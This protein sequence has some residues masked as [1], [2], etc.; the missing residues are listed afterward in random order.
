MTSLTCDVPA[1]LFR[2][3]TSRAETTGSNMS[4]LVS[5]LLTGSLD[6]TFHT[7]FQ[8][9]TSS[10]LIQGVYAQAVTCQKILEHGDFGLG[11]FTGLDGEMVVL[12]SVVYRVQGDGTVSKAEPNAGAPFAVV[13]SF[14]PSSDDTVGPFSSFQELKSVCD[15]HRRSDNLF[16]AIR[17]DGSF[18]HVRTR[19]VSPPPAGGRLVDAAKSQKEFNYSDVGGTLVGIYS[20]TFS[21]AFSV[22]GYHFH[23]LSDDRL[24]G[25]HVLDVSADSLRLRVEELSAFHLAL[26]ETEPFLQADLSHASAA[27]LKKSES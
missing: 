18:S 20:P 14:S 17:V 24:D 19:A 21:G 7:L 25:G 10:S 1:P 2:E 16:Y 13:T 23:F 5:E 8:V 15:G 26:P 11:T 22:P 4:S 12:D 6:V 27:D 3:L 9:S